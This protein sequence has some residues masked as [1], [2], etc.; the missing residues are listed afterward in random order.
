MMLQLGTSSAMNLIFPLETAPLK[1]TAFQ[2]I[3]ESIDKD[4]HIVASA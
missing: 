4:S 2:V 1:K 3:S